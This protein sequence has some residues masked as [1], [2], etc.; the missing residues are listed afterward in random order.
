[1]VTNGYSPTAPN[2]GHQVKFSAPGFGTIAASPLHEP[3]AE[4]VS[5]LKATCLGS[6]ALAAIDRAALAQDLR[7]YHVAKSVYAG[8]PPAV[9]TLAKT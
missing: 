9:M 5:L 7:A 1:M 4:V 6:R 2:D 8:S 3:H